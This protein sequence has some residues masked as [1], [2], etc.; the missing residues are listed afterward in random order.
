LRRESNQSLVDIMAGKV[1]NTVGI[2]TNK[3]RNQRNTKRSSTVLDYKENAEAIKKAAVGLEKLVSNNDSELDKSLSH[4]KSDFSTLINGGNRTELVSRTQDII[5]PIKELKLDDNTKSEIDG[6]DTSQL[7]DNSAFKNQLGDSDDSVIDTEGMIDFHDMITKNDEH[8][9]K[10]RN[11]NLLSRK[12]IQ[13]LTKFFLKKSTTMM[14]EK[15]DSIRSHAHKIE[16]PG[17]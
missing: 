5:E 7:L 8:Y 12:E 6:K 10:A 3:T 15:L 16:Y 13:D 11:H 4:D 9:K 17:F 14:Y 1:T 2:N